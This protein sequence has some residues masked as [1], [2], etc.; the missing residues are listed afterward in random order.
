MAIKLTAAL[1]A[2][3]IVDGRGVITLPWAKYFASRQTVT[4]DSDSPSDALIIE[5]LLA[6]AGAG[7]SESAEDAEIL[8][9]L[10]NPSEPDAVHGASALIDVGAIPKVTAPGVLGESALTDDGS[11]NVYATGRNVLAGE[12]SPVSSAAGRT[13]LGAKGNAGAG[14]LEL[15]QTDTDA[16]A[17]IIGVVQ[18]SDA[19]CTGPE[20]RLAV[21]Q[22]LTDGVTANNRGGLIRFG[23]KPDGAGAITAWEALDNLGNHGFGGN[24]SP[25]YPVDV[26]GDINVSGV[27][28]KG[29]VGGVTNSIGLTVTSAT[30]QYKD[31]AGLNQSL[32]VVTSVSVTANAFTGGIKTT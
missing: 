26:T 31:W 9:A 29:G 27:F 2:T 23:T 14:A 12:T 1:L 4:P 8:N 5:A 15:T 17:H 28:R 11:A 25:S 21:I 16:T 7:S 22:F 20:K 32:L 13:Y 19:N 10:T 24:T 3:P 30:I 6:S 18:G